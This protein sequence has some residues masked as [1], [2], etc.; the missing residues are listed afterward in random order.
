MRDERAEI[1]G[2]GERMRFHGV[3]DQGLVRENN[4]D[5]YLLPLEHP[6]L[7]IDAERIR[8]NGRLFVL[9]DG[10]GGHAAGEVASRM[11]C[12]TIMQGYYAAP[13]SE[14]PA[15]LLL[16][17]TI[18]THRILRE[19][20][21]ANVNCFGMSA[22]LVALLI[23]DRTAYY[24]SAGD[25]RIYRLDGHDS[26]HQVTP[27][28]SEIWPLYVRGELTKDQLR[29][30]PRNHII[31]SGIGLTREPEIFHHTEPAPPHRLYLLCSDGLT[32]LVS[33]VEIEEELRRPADLSQ[34]AGHL[35][36]KAHHYGGKDNITMILV[37]TD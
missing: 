2:E 24:V 13:E 26:L 19:F 3:T 11:A 25:S 35:V 8:R 15:S 22:T 9:C 7:G 29:A 4:E 27:D 32:D 10:V 5:Y 36:Q 30:H 20:G 6:G 17:I 18:D 33:D 31:T 16:E 37:E 28:H 14:N 34:R 12:E 1:P 21:R 23:R